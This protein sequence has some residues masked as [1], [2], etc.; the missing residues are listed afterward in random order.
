MM[1]SIYIFL[2][3]WL[4]TDNF[5]IQEYVDIIAGKVNNK[6]LSLLIEPFQCFKCLTF[7]T[8]LLITL[9]PFNALLFSFLASLYLKIGK[10]YE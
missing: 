2:I 6:F 4:F 7:W 8:V 1:I 3:S 5:Y 9:N 10:D